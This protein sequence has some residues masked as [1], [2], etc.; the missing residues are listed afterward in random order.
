MAFL[1]N[2]VAEKTIQDA[3][4][5]STSK[6]ISSAKIP[7][8]L[9]IKQTQEDSEKCREG[10]LS[11]P[12]EQYSG[13]F[14]GISFGL[15]YPRLCLGETSHLEKPISHFRQPRLNGEPRLLPL[16]GC[17]ELPPLLCWGGVDG[18]C[19]GAWTFIFT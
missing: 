5:K 2:G 11:K 12:E 9:Y 17:G 18:D 16:P 19:M 8:T 3:R 13:G 1:M 10:R 15:I 6:V 14:S 7:W 4:R